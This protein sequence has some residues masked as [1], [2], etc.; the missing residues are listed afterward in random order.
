MSILTPTITSIITSIITSTF[1]QDEIDRASHA[2]IFTIVLSYILM[3]VY[4]GITLGDIDL[5]F[6]GCLLNSKVGAKL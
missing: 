6:K 5:S 3:F 1:S 4:V 2:D